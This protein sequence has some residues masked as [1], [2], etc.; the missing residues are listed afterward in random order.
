MYLD[1]T[2]NEVELIVADYFSML[3]KELRG[4]NFKKSE[5]RANMLKILSTRS[6]GA[7]EFK[8][9]NISAALIQLGLPYIR[10]YKPRFNFQKDKIFNIIETYLKANKLFEQLFIEFSNAI[11][12]FSADLN[13]PLNLVDAPTISNKEDRE[14]LNIRKPIKVNYLEREQSNR[15][16]G[17]QGE[18]LVLYYERQNLITAGLNSIAKEVKWVSKEQGDG[19]GYDILSMNNNGTP[20]YI[21]VKTTKLGKETPFFFSSNEFEFSNEFKENYYLYR[22]FNLAQKPNLFILNGSFK[23]FCEM[24]PITYRGSF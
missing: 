24:K 11:P 15:N 18:E 20:K 23:D 10:G 13:H 16:L 19:L 5:H 2:D 14:I 22:V 3:S 7:V 9:Q 8:H 12:Q 21:E 4:I 6:N 17:Y 1:W